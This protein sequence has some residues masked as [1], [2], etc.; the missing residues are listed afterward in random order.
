MTQLLAAKY[1]SNSGDESSSSR[2]SQIVTMNMRSF[3]MHNVDVDIDNKN[4]ISIATMEA[5]K[6]NVI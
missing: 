2:D 4:T 1:Y 5:G 6:F 3:G